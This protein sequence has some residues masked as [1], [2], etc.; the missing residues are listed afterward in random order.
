MT[1]AHANILRTIYSAHVTHPDGH[2]KGRAVAVVP[3]GIA[4]TVADAMNFM[5]SIVD[6]RETMAGGRV[7]LLSDGYWS[8][9]F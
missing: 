9:G 6:R 7:A 1:D 4:D 8:H 3:A 2:W 5:G